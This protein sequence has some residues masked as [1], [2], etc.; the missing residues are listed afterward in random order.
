VNKLADL[1]WKGR[2]TFDL[3]LR[4]N[5]NVKKT[6]LSLYLDIANVFNLKYLEESGFANADDRTVYMR[7]LHLARYNGDIAATAE[8]YKALGCIAG[9][10]KPGDVKSDDK[11]YINMPNREFLT[12]LNPRAITFG[13][14]LNF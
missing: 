8:E 11:P 12:Y 2:T 10:D 6:A 3:R 4:K 7:S 9:D 1:Q 5:I 14:G 13:I